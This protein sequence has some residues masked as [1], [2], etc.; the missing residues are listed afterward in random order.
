MSDRDRPVFVG[1]SFL[2]DLDRQLSADRGPAGEPS[3]A[4]FLAIEMP[5]IVRT[6]AH[7]FD[8]LPMVVPD[9]P[10]HRVL[11]GGGSLVR[12]FAVTGQ[13]RLDGSVEL[14]E[15]EIDVG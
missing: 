15:L 10:D 8:D 14:L 2:D 1:G 12:G 13:L 5:D 3:A 6:F 9:R 4:D 7:E 11:I